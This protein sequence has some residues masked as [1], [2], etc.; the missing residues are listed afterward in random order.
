MNVDDESNDVAQSRANLKRR[1]ETT[2]LF[3]K[4]LPSRCDSPSTV[5]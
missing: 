2:L 3:L 5:T 1:E 4:D